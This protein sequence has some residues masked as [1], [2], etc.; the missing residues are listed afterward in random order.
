MTIG[1]LG[2]G[3]MGGVLLR[4]LC[5]TAQQ[6]PVRFLVSSKS[7]ATG[8]LLAEETGAVAV[9]NA[10]L[11]R[12]SDVIFVCVK[13]ADAPALVS[14]LSPALDGKLLIS[15]V[16]GWGLDSIRSSAGAGVRIVRSM[17]NICSQVGKGVTV[18]ADGGGYS[19]ADRALVARLF[20][21]VGS[22][23]FIRE[24]LIDAATGLCGSGPAY[25]FLVMEA[26]SDGGVAAGLPRDL[27]QR[28]AAET[29]AGAGEMQIATGTHP[30]VLREMV[31][32][33]GGTTAAALAHLE[34]SATRA[35]FSGAV[36][37]A[38]KRAKE[39]SAPR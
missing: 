34:S 32:S 38:C 17:P 39:L 18:V 4:A 12:D 23:H 1:F 35:A 24:S 7:G 29:I 14:G 36:I 28:L 3:R 16:A 10:D 31:T 37:A 5:G 8:A 2:C 27:A 11:A 9:S 20:G 21:A 15:I 30:A 22:V 6:P 25:L 13:P 33:P 19:E 26:L